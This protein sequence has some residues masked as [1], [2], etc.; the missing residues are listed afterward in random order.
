MAVKEYFLK[1]NSKNQP[2]V[3]E[4]FEARSTLLIRLIL[5]D[6]GTYQTH[7]LMGV[8]LVSRWRYT[9]IDRLSELKSE[10][11]KQAREYLPIEVYSDL[12]IDVRQSSTDPILIN[13]IIADTETKESR[14]ININK[15]TWELSDL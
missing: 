8:G 11:I 12:S 3:A 5:L 6:P 14:V 15:D 13:I 9:D 4:D 1:T 2:Y 10:I 7:P